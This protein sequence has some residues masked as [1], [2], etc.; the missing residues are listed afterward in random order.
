MAPDTT[1]AF[2]MVR[3]VLMPANSAAVEFAPVA[4]SSYP[5]VVFFNHH[6]RPMMMMM[7]RTTDWGNSKFSN[8]KRGVSRLDCASRDVD[9]EFWSAPF[10]GPAT[11]A[12]VRFIATALSMMVVITSWPFL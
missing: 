12:L 6:A 9:G 10:M 3:L 7:P 11:I 1:I 4:R 8:L 5:A 2:I